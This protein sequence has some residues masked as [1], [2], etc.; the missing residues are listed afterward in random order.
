VAAN[1]LFTRREQLER[2]VRTVRPGEPLRLP[3]I[4]FSRDR[5]VFVTVGPRSSRGYALR[6]VAAEEERGRA[7]V[8]LHEDT[9]SLGD[10]QQARIT[11]PYRLLVFRK[12]D[13]PVYLQLQGRP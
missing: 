11:Y 2:Y 1:L 3:Q 4:D 8:V 13:K 7:F 5:A 12:A 9:P 10:P 6:V